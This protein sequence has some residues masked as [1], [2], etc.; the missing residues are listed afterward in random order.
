M[1]DVRQIDSFA[2][3]IE[4]RFGP[5]PPTAAILLDLA[6]LREIA[7]RFGIVRVDAGPRAIAMT[8]E[9]AAAE[10][11]RKIIVKAG[12]KAR[13]YWKEDRLVSDQ[14]SEAGDRVA[15]LFKLFEELE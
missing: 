10:R 11:W 12:G 4:D 7:R 14:P 9:P 8:F 6:R 5:P 1:R 15:A 3:E 2:E 13:L